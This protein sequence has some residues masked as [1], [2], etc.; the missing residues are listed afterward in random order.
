MHIEAF[1]LADEFLLKNNIG[2]V[3]GCI[4]VPASDYYAKNKLKTSAIPLGNVSFSEFYL[5][6]IP[7]RFPS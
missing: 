6:G 5:E 7:V 3:I 4:F 2:E 1:K